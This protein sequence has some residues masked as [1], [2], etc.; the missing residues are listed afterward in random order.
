MYAFGRKYTLNGE[1]EIFPGQR[2]EL[3]FLHCG[4]VKVSHSPHSAHMVKEEVIEIL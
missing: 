1:F 3:I 2:A 4:V